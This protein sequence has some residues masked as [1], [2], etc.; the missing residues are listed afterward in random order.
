MPLRSILRDR[1]TRTAA[2]RLLELWKP[3]AGWTAIVWA[4]ELIL[5]A[6]LSGLVLG[7]LLI[8]GERVVIS[9]VELVSWFLSPWGI[10]Y[11][12]VSGGLILMAAVLRFAGI[13]RILTDSRN[14][15][16]VSL[17]R[18]AIHLALRAPAIFRLCVGVTGLAFLALLPLAAGFG[19]IRELFLGP[20]GLN[21]YL[22]VSPPE[23]K[24][25]LWAG[26][27]WAVGWGLAALA[28]LLR[29][30]LALPAFLDGHRPLR[31][32]L[33]ESWR[34]TAGKGGRIF[35]ILGLAI[36]FWVA[37]RAGLDTALFRAAGLVVHGLG[38]PFVGMVYASAA[39]LIS[40]IV[41][42]AIVSF[43]GFSFVSALLTKF[44]Y[45][46][47]APLLRPPARVKARAKR[48]KSAVR[49]L[50]R[51]LQPRRSIPLLA[52]LLI[53]AGALTFARLQ[54]APVRI[55]ILIAAHR[56]AGYLAPEN[57]LSAIELSIA[58]GADSVEI[59]V[60]RARDG[61]I[62]VFHDADLMRLTGDPRRIREMSYRD[63]SGVD[64]GSGFGPEYAGERIP[65]LEQCLERAK[66]RIGLQIELKYFGFDPRLAEDC[67]RLVRAHGMEKQAVLMSLH[68]RGVRQLRD[69]A[70]DIPVGY[71]SVLS[72]GDLAR[73]DADFVGVPFSRAT[74][75]FMR[76]ARRKG[77]PVHVWGVNSPARMITVIERGAAGIITDVPDVAVRLRRELRELS[78][79]ELLL[80][81]FRRVWELP[82]DEETAAGFE[83][84]AQR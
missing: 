81:R 23:W 29:S 38:L 71:L 56:A 69:L 33:K 12:L 18:T 59:D 83:P 50:K 34:N 75:A 45:E 61:V 46:D 72:A 55:D 67:V 22:E 35:R 10:A 8:R 48:P 47:T 79:A 63:L 6:P 27:A 52:V 62:V 49:A 41:L 57:S 2:G 51:W 11:A 42:D 5:L 15:H 84:A 21:Y 68:P 53:G 66:G 64:I 31:A 43:T 25:A 74:P 3:M 58:I 24:R 40:A 70:P 30:S 60:Q 36:L 28:L 13:F 4:V 80:L 73:V 16:P 39:Y 1:V 78:P 76:A 7:R 9:N 26:G 32:A 65:T 77:L 54:S 20:H 19:L 14:G 44:Y 37:V 82:G 17:M